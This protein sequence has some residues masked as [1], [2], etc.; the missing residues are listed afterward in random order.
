[1]EDD[2]GSADQPVDERRVRHAAE[3]DVRSQTSQLV[4]EQ[5]WRSVQHAYL[6]AAR[7]Q[8]PDEVATGEPGA[9]G[10]ERAHAASIAGARGEPP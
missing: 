5:P 3:R 1:M 7:E 4:V 8:S 10:H 2:V 6:V 9:A